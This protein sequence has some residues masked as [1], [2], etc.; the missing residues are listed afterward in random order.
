MSQQLM[1][2]CRYPKTAMQWVCVGLCLAT[3]KCLTVP[4]SYNSIPVLDEFFSS[5]VVFRFFNRSVSILICSFTEHNSFFIFRYKIPQYR[6]GKVMF[7]FARNKTYYN[8]NTQESKTSCL[9]RLSWSYHSFKVAPPAVIP[10][11]YLY[12]YRLYSATTRDT[13]C[14]VLLHHM[15]LYRLPI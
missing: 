11:L 12:N 2:N 3:Q 9:S 15:L 1:S 5:F 8:R 6:I 10:L 14:H 13:S 4:L 7:R